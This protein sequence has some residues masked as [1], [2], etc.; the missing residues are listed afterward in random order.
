MDN[1]L[2]S[3]DQAS[4]FAQNVQSLA[5]SGM[6][7]RKAFKKSL[8]GHPGIILRGDSIIFPDGSKATLT[9]EGLLVER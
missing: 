3:P 7:L 4:T 6:N 9:A 2:Y 5:K 1:V 8:K